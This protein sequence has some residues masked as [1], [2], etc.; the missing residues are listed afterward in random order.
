MNRPVRLM[1]LG[2]GSSQINAF[3]RAGERGFVTILADRDVHA[4]ARELADQF[5][6]VST[7]DVDGVTAAARKHGVDAILAVG[8]D[9][10]VYTAAVAS[11]R[12][13]LPFPLTPAQAAL[14]TNKRL[15]KERFAAAGIPSAR[16]ALLGP[17]GD[18]RWEYPPHVVAP[19]HPPLVVKPVD[20]QGQRGIITATSFEAAEDHYAVARSFSREQRVLVEEYY[21]SR[22]VTVSGWANNPDDVEIWTITDRVTLEQ[23]PSLG[24]CLAHRYPSYHAAGHTKQICSL[25]RRICT[26]FALSS[27]PIYFQMLIGSDLNENAQSPVLVNEIAFRLGG[28]YEDQSIPTVTPH[29]PLDRQLRSIEQAVAHGHHLPGT[30]TMDSSTSSGE[31]HRYF[32]VPLIFARPGVVQSLEGDEVLRRTPGV[33]DCRFLLPVGTVIRSIENSTQRI[34][35]AVVHASNRA[36]LNGLIDTLFN[37]LVA[38]DTEGRN[39]ILDSRSAAC[40]PPT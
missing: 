38:K 26:A 30:H 15:M 37:T 7:F 12:L 35:Y 5:A 33:A 29:D 16:Y 21:P 39:M 31:E 11:S 8:T 23:P 19:L 28:A 13:G 17:P 36:E 4:P 22:E 25:T 10:P 32:A 18:G 24:V 3:R 9:Q 2:G 20:S 1:I 40:H 34:A 14:V 27:G 6:E